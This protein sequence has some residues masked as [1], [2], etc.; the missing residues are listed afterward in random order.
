MRV[1]VKDIAKAAGVSTTAVSLVL[2]GKPS[3]LSDATKEKITRV[4][5]ELAFQQ[6]SLHSESGERVKTMGL[7]VPSVSDP[8]YLNLLSCVHSCA[9]GFGYTVFTCVSEEDSERTCRAVESL[10][11]KNVDG[12]LLVAPVTVGE[13]AYTAAGSTIT[14]DVPADALAIARQRQTVKKSWAAKRRKS[15]RLK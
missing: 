2:N 15:K 5:R 4:A 7:V 12:I 9:Y 6:E 13:G 10:A 14:E 1:K 3:R 8:F 11:T